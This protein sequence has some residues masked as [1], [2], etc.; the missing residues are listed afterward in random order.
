MKAT[1][2]TAVV[3]GITGQDGAYLSQLLI[4]KGYTVIGLVRAISNVNLKRLD[5]LGIRDSIEYCECDL[6]DLSQVVK[7]ITDRKPAEI[8][9]LAAQSSVSVS[10][11]QPI[12]TV[13]FNIVS[14]LNILEAIRMSKLNTR[15][16]QASSSDMYGTVTKLPI[17]ESTTFNPASPYAISKVAAHHLTVNYRESYNI[18]ACC[19]ILFNHESYLR[20]EAFVIKKVIK[21]A[22][23][24]LHGRKKF[25]E[26]G[27]LDIRRDF[28]SAQDY[29]HAMWLMLQQKTADD[30]II[31][32]GKSLLLKDVVEY[33]LNSLNLPLTKLK[34]KK[35]L[36][37]PTEIPNIYGSAAKARKILNWRYTKNFY[38]ALDE[39]IREE[40]EN[41]GRVELNG[42]AS[43]AVL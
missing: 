39:M 18:Y 5:Y 26:V 33:V 25:V 7:I 35:D 24:V 21:G 11:T 3:T 13:Q 2:K 14:V 27:N 23:D 8:Y 12:E 20:G 15:F 29:V 34:I 36:F 43:H 6:L 9:N 31:C 42:S 4:S 22:V 10:F 37:R 28:G 17:T 32:S 40:S 19:G 41:Y 1:S 38:R 16:Y 30:F